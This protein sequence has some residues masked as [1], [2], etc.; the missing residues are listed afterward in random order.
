MRSA[1]HRRR[2]GWS[3]LAMIMG[4]GSGFRGLRDYHIDS[5]DVGG[6]CT[7]TSIDMDEI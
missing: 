4:F 3:F 6:C 7:I 5:L 2:D 1:F